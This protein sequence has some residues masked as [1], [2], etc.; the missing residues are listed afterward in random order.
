MFTVHHQCTNSFE[1]AHVCMNFS[2]I[3][4]II[5]FVPSLLLPSCST[6][7]S[8]ACLIWSRMRV[9]T[10]SAPLMVGSIGVGNCRAAVAAAQSKH[11][12][13]AGK[14]NYLCLKVA[15]AFNL[16]H[17][18]QEPSAS[19]PVCCVGGVPPRGLSFWLIQSQVKGAR[20]HVETGANMPKQVAETE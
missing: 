2:L 20:D 13:T 15:Q 11:V 4:A 16:Q 19:A 5:T 10:S 3:L 18:N 17:P 14:R 6:K 9:C 1:H 7:G 8:E 12:C